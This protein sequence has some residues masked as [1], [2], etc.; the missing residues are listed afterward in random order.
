[1]QEKARKKSIRLNI[2]FFGLGICMVLSLLLFFYLIP[3]VEGNIVDVKK[4]KI[5][6]I[7]DMSMC[8]IYRAYNEYRNGDLT[9]EEAKLRAISIVKGLRYGP[10]GKDYLWIN[11][12]Q[13][14]MIMHPYRPDLD[15]KD[16]SGFTDPNGKHLF[17]EMVKVCRNKGNGYVDYMWQWKDDSTKIVP[18]ISYVKMFEPWKWVVGTGI[19][20]EDAREEAS[21][22]IR[23][24]KILLIG[25]FAFILILMTGTG[26]RLISMLMKP[27]SVINACM[28]RVA[29]GDLESRMEDQEYHEISV[30]AEKFNNSVGNFSAVIGDIRDMSDHVSEYTGQMND[31]IASLSDNAQ[32]Q[33][34]SV[35]QVMSTI[36]EISAGMD[37]IAE[38]ARD[39]SDIMGGFIIKIDEL[40]SMVNRINENIR[41]V[42]RQ[43]DDISELAETGEKYMNMMDDSMKRIMRSS[44]EMINIITIIN[45]ISER[46]NLLS[47]NASIEA[48]RAGD[49]G[50]GFAVV[51]DEIS[52]LADQTASSIKEIS[53]LIKTSEKEIIHEKNN[54]EGTVNTFSNIISGINRIS[55]S[56]RTI[57]NEM[58]TQLNV[59]AE[60]AS[61]ADRVRIRADEIK[62]STEEQKVAVSEIVRNITATNDILQE[63]AAST[64]ELASNTDHFT[65]ISLVLKQKVDYFRN[66]DS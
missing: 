17:V 16:I 47:L 56:V 55:S 21:Q 61:E 48:A 44:G 6:D 15:R 37:V 25:V 9:E 35:E 13:P 18:K 64:E 20:V 45:D 65:G 8:V 34:A 63:N 59:N 12:M 40:N 36:E 3:E 46:I 62:F 24:V 22:K 2:L 42:F 58:E 26:I 60:V 30:I 39:Q 11:D 41:D 4:Q 49:A 33:A 50:R 51:A 57:S 14:R 23:S 66:G 52:K 28:E 31:T 10:E 54:V 43:S 32:N 27:L 38:R 5:K 1:M 19:Y 7:T 53:G 29:G